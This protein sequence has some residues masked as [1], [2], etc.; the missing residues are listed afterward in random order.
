MTDNEQEETWLVK[1]K[2]CTSEQEDWFSEMIV[3]Q[4][5]G[6]A[7]TFQRLVDQNTTRQGVDL[8][9]VTKQGTRK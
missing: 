5:S 3:E 8:T 9:Q 1:A 4:A 7:Q 6:C 2:Q